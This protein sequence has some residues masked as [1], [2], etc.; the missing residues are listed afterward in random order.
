MC[1]PR[2]CEVVSERYDVI[3][4]RAARH[5]AVSIAKVWSGVSSAVAQRV[6]LSLMRVESA[7]AGQRPYFLREAQQLLLFLRRELAVWFTLQRFELLTRGVEGGVSAQF[8]N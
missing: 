8:F 5:I 6:C 7:L 2:W 3:A 1:R 4:L